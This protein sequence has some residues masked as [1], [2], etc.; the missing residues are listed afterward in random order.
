MIVHCRSTKTIRYSLLFSIL[1]V[2]WLFGASCAQ[3][4]AIEVEKTAELLAF[5]AADE[6]KGRQAF[7]QEIVTFEEFI[8][9]EFYQ[10]GL[11]KLPELPGF[12]QEFSISEYQIR[13]AEGSLGAVPLASNTLFGRVYSDSLHWTSDQMSSFNVHSIGPGEPFRA[14]FNELSS[15]TEASLIFV[16]AD[17]SEIFSRYQQYYSRPS[18]TMKSVNTDVVFV[19]AP[20]RFNPQ[21]HAFDL[22]IYTDKTEHRLANVAGYI[23][24][25][26]SDEIIL[27]SAHHDHIGIRTAVEGDSIANGANDNA[28]GVTAVIQLAHHFASQ[29]TPE[30]SIYFVTFTAEEMGGYGSQYFSEQLNPDQIVAMFNIEMIGKPAV[31]GPNSAWITGYERSTFGQILTDSAPDSIYTFYADPYPNQNL[32]YR[33]DNRTL[34]RLG[35]PAHS[36][37]T[38]PIDVDPDYHQVSDEF[39]TI[40]LNHLNNTTKAIARAAMGMI[41]G[42]QTPTRIDPATVD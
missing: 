3:E 10:A 33:S 36:I 25:K 41:S 14:R 32:F 26:R 2:G 19:L 16:N 12:R 23:P 29:P 5:L 39:D 34:A 35:V 30:R 6:H 11:K 17:H 21:D 15:S 40:N 38:T 4:Q 7:S 27:F 31:S 22:R 20:E 1:C 24:G 28:S 42:E 37:S 13:R 8:A 9:Q 18:R